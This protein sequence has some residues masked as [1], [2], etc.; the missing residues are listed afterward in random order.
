MKELID[1]FS[2]TGNI[3]SFF[4]ALI[5][6]AGIIKLFEKIISWASGK[7][8]KY[9]NYRRGRE[10]EKEKA[11][12]QSERIKEIDDKLD[13]HIIDAESKLD[14]RIHEV[15]IKLDAI[16]DKVDSIAK[17]FGDYETR[18]KKVNIITLRDKINY[19]YKRCLVD[20]YIL[21]KDKHDFKDAY[22]E[23]IENGGD[24]Y[25]ETE[26]EPFI[27]TLRVFLTEEDAKRVMLGLTGGEIKC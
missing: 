18:Q 9:Y 12:K 5:I 17:A 15:D 2:E 6:L 23:Y 14:E 25:V 22:D 3:V 20:G 13:K 27:H 26:I 11:E 7:L 16:T 4:V 19:I 8:T 24:S 1:Y 10:T 21:D